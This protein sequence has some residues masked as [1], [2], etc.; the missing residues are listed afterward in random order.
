VPN[1]SKDGVETCL[2]CAEIFKGDTITNLLLYLNVTEFLEEAQ[3]SQRDHKTWYVSWNI[4]NCCQTVQRSYVK[5]IAT[6]EWPSKS[7]EIALLDKPYI[8]Y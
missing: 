1:V 6:A 3:L 5:K 8:T 7:L 4:V 2:K